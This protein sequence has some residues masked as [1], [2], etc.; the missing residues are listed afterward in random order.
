MRIENS[1]VS[2][3][4]RAIITDS[5]PIGHVVD[6]TDGGPSSMID[7]CLG[8]PFNDVFPCHPPQLQEA[9]SMNHT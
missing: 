6:H 1:E 8:L 2:K 5:E 4:P 7:F 9:E 3:H